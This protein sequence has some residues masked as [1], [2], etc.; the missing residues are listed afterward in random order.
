M[1]PWDATLD[2]RGWDPWA[3][4]DPQGV[5]SLGS[6][7]WGTGLPLRIPG[8]VPRFQFR[9]VL[10][11]TASGSDRFQFRSVRFDQFRFVSQPSYLN[12]GFLNSRRRKFVDVLGGSDPNRPPQGIEVFL[13]VLV[14]RFFLLVPLSRLL[15]SSRT[16][17]A[18]LSP[19]GRP[20]RPQMF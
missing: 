1:D 15:V 6:W 5:R 17:G 4:G 20:T 2:P 18:S 3:L 7:A 10:V 13:F 8:E 19:L 16:P 11:Q 14:L 9:L 12:E